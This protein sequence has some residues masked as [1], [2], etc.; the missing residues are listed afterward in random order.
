ML[1]WTNIFEFLTSGA[2]CSAITWLVSKTIRTVRR[3]KEVHDTYK[4]MY[5]DLH[6]T[7]I[8]VQ[9]DNKRLYKAV[10]KLERTIAKATSCRHYDN[11]PMRSELQDKQ[12]DNRDIH[13]RIRQPNRNKKENKDDRSDTASEG[14]PVPSGRLN[15][16][17]TSRIMLH[18]E[19]EPD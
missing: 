12:D 13:S 11:C 16:E 5:E 4:S 18:Q 1:E 9:N 15:E 17:A 10:S 8:E 2:V 14:K 19:V 3:S 6:G 7:I